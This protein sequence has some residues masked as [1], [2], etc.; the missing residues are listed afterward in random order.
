MVKLALIIGSYVLQM[1]DS[2][3]K[4]GHAEPRAV[5]GDGRMVNGR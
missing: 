2:V 1:M 4:D 5:C 3:L